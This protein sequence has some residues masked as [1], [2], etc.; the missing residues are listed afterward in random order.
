M[1]EFQLKTDYIE[2]YKLIKMLDL[3]E[4]GGQ[5]KLMIEEGEVLR[6]GEVEYRKR[7]KIRA[8][9]KIELLGTQVTVVGSSSIS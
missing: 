2:L 1:M 3:A 5:A 8:G 6:N 9:E 4:S 7:A